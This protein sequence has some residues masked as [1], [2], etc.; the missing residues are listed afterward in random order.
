MEQQD[1]VNHIINACNICNMPE[2]AKEI[3]LRFTNRMTRTGGTATYKSNLIKISIPY[4]IHATEEERTNTIYH[5]ICHLLA[6]NKYSYKIKPHGWEWRDLMRKC[7]QMPSRTH[8]V[9][10]GFAS[11]SRGLILVSCN[12][13]EGCRVGPTVYKR[14]KL[15]VGYRCKRCK[16][17]LK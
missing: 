4:W 10:T 11:R 3:S 1:I 7:G 6:K 15:G 8:K 5:E 17:R 12:C 13:S 14:I 9:D 16:G 2:M